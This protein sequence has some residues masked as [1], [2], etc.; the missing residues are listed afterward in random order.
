[1]M[2]TGYTVTDLMTNNPVKIDESVNVQEA[3]KK[4]DEKKVGSL[5]VM[6]GKEFSGLVTEQDVVYKLVAKDGKA[7]ETKIKDIMTTKD[8]IISIEPSRDIYEAI[9][10]MGDQ[11]IRRLPVMK[12]GDLKGLITRKDILKI[13]PT[14]FDITVEKIRLREEERKLTINPDNPYEDEE[15]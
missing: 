4:M 8:N 11:G 15:N 9:K 6:D 1:M 13:E 5:I 2:R 7:S 12:K 14:L 10:L 3:A